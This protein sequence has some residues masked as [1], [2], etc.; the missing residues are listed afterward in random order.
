ME[1]S[2]K[3]EKIQPSVGYLNKIINRINNKEAADSIS[4]EFFRSRYLLKEKEYQ[5]IF[6][7]R[8]K[9]G[10]LFR[11]CRKEHLTHRSSLFVGSMNLI[12]IQW[13]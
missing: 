10:F 9:K 3:G 4:L 5:C 8:K 6:E 2:I 7:S 12:S 11:L 13:D 1:A